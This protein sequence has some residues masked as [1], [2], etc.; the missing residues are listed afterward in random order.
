[1]IWLQTLGYIQ[2]NL[3]ASPPPSHFSVDHHI[4]IRCDNVDS[5]VLTFTVSAYPTDSIDY[6]AYI[7]AIIPPSGVCILPH[8]PHYKNERK[9][10]TRLTKN[11][12]RQ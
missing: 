10:G 5:S 6:P 1:M 9:E 4:L 12:I 2:T 11:E 3:T 8:G 7:Q